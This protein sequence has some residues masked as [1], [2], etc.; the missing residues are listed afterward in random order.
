M[1]T[2]EEINNAQVT[3]AEDMKMSIGKRIQSAISDNFLAVLEVFDA[4][5]LVNLHCGKKAEKDIQLKI[6]CGEYD[7][8][9]VEESKNI[10]MTVSNMKHIQESGMDFDQRLAHR[11]MNTLKEAI[12][13]GIWKHLCSEWFLDIKNVPL[14][15]TDLVL[16]KFESTESKFSTPFDATFTMMFDD[17]TSKI[18]RLHEQSVYSSFYK[19][20][21]IY[22][23]AKPPTCALLDIV[24]AKGCPEA[25]A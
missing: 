4:Q 13:A 2:E 8:N 20:K 17:G 7:S 9:G 12:S 10:M 22:S 21:D 19:N 24:L 16:V 5:A 18:V 25:V 11:Y 3:F 14:K 6:S 23:I 15:Q 1:R